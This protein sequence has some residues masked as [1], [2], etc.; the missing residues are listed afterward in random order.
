MGL[1]HIT[2]N[3]NNNRGYYLGQG[4]VKVKVLYKNLYK[5]RVQGNTE[6]VYRYKPIQLHTS[7]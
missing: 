7:P 2:Y 4:G 6:Y 3:G 5:E 1:H